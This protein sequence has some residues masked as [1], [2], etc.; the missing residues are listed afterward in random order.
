MPLAHWPTKIDC[1]SNSNSWPKWK[2]A[3]VVSPSLTLDVQKKLRCLLLVFCLF[4]FG[5]CCCFVDTEVRHVWLNPVCGLQCPKNILAPQAQLRP[6]CFKDARP[7]SASILGEEGRDPTYPNRSLLDCFL[8]RASSLCLSSD[9]H[10]IGVAA[11]GK[12][13]ITFATRSSGPLGHCFVGRAWRL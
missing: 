3:T 12:H 9:F 5:S 13:P 1:S 4:G 7:Y 11:L 6:V 8:K 10:R 2:A